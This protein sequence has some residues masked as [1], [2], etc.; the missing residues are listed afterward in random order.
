MNFSDIIEELI[1]A[2]EIPNTTVKRD[3]EAVIVT[4]C[5][6]MLSIGIRDG[7]LLILDQNDNKVLHDFD[8]SSEDLEE[9]LT[10]LVVSHFE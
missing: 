3:G 9:K 1:R 4:N 2:A 7:D 5:E 8:L 6:R 10:K